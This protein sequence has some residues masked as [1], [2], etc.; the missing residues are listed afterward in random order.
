ML[1]TSVNLIFKPNKNYLDRTEQRVNE[2]RVQTYTV[3]PK[4]SYKECKRVGAGQ[5]NSYHRPKKMPFTPSGT[6]YST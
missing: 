2:I 6:S 1:N 5:P 4:F 3:K